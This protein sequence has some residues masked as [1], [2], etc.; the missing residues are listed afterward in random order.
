MKKKHL[1]KK[2]DSNKRKKR[3]L[4]LYLFFRLKVRTDLKLNDE[5]GNKKS[6]KIC[7]SMFNLSSLQS[8]SS[9]SVQSIAFIQEVAPSA[10]RKSDAGLLV[11]DVWGGVET[12]KRSGSTR[13]S[14][15]SEVS[16]GHL[17][18]AKCSDV[19]EKTTIAHLQSI[20]GHLQ[21]LTSEFAR[22]KLHV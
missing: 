19:C 4:A 8:C 6:N 16:V 7:S 12:A 13:Y 14:G 22:C 17:V 10:S 15:S 1:K 9:C 11:T 5:P 2:N 18:L 3:F 21:S 20:S